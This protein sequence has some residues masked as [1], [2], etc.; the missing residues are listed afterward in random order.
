M[1]WPLMRGSSSGIWCR[2]FDA[3]IRTNTN[4]LLSR[5]VLVFR[6]IYPWPESTSRFPIF[7]CRTTCGLYQKNSKMCHCLLGS[8]PLGNCRMKTEWPYLIH[9]IKRVGRD[10]IFCIDCP[11]RHVYPLPEQYAKAVSD[12]DIHTLNS[13]KTL[14]SAIK[15]E[16]DDASRISD[17]MIE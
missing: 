6:W 15:R 14:Y 17:L 9:E 7:F 11:R 13:Y 4:W 5:L 8:N 3:Q 16:R 10:V 2:R 1:Y 12:H